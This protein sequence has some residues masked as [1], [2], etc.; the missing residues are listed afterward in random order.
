MVSQGKLRLVLADDE[1]SMRSGLSELF[2]WNEMGYY[3]AGIFKNG[4]ET[5]RY[6]EQFDADVLLTDIRMPVMD[7]LKPNRVLEQVY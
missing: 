5:L 6:L 3:V 7:G 2:P 4:W 1:Y